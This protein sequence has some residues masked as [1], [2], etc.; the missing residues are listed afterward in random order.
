MG[1]EVLNNIPKYKANPDDL[2]IYIRSGDIFIN[3]THPLYSQ[4][5]L[6]FIKK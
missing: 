6:F 2:Y 1:D 4:P 3:Q 5:P